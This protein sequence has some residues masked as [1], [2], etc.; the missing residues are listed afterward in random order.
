MRHYCRFRLFL[1]LL[2]RQV[3]PPGSIPE[4]YR[5]KGR[6]TPRLVWDVATIIWQQ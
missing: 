4:F 1:W 2:G 6:F 5:S 3:E